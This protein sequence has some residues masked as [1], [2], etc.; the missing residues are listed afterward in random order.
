MKEGSEERT[1]VKHIHESV[2]TTYITQLIFPTLNGTC[3]RRPLL[4]Q[5]LNRIK[6]VKKNRELFFRDPVG[7]IRNRFFKT[8]IEIRAFFKKIFRFSNFY[9]GVFRR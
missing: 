2:R 8:A 5:R 4:F 7:I 1:I 9:L 6:K 3:V